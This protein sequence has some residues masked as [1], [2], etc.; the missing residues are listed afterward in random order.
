MSLTIRQLVYRIS[1]FN[2]SSHR[3]RSIICWHGSPRERC[4]WVGS[5]TVQTC[6]QRWSRLNSVQTFLKNAEIGNGLDQCEV[7]LDNALNLFQVK[8]R[9]CGMLRSTIV[10]RRYSCVLE[11]RCSSLGSLRNT[12]TLL[13]SIT[14]RST[15]H[16]VEQSF[17]ITQAPLASVDQCN[18]NTKHSRHAKFRRA[19]GW[20]DHGGWS[21]V[22]VKVLIPLQIWSFRLRGSHRLYLCLKNKI[23]NT[24]SSTNEADKSSPCNGNPSHCESA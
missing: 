15:R 16:N 5:L 2:R 4:I 14:T 11:A 7:E 10:F 24:I 9:C 18:G 21:N 13:Y 1:K 23:V 6:L 22:F 17:R 3:I 20:E 19:G 8:L 12:S